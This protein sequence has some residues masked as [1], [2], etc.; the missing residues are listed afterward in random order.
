MRWMEND[1][2][3]NVEYGFIYCE[4]EL[5]Q[6]KVK[7]CMGWIKN[8]QWGMWVVEWY[9]GNMKYATQEIVYI[10]DREWSFRNGKCGVWNGVLRIW[11][12]IGET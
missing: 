8:G 5:L 6:G 9:I 12:V 10:M 3:R 1:V 2:T 7:L 11:I 4:Y